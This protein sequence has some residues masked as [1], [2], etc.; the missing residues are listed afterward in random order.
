MQVAPSAASSFQQQL[1]VSLASAEASVASMK[2]RVAE[3]NR[4]LEGLKAAVNAQPQVEAEFVQLTRDYEVTKSNYER[5][6][7]RREQAQ[8]SGEMESNASVMDFRV[9]DPPTVPAAP[10]APNRPALIT[11]IMLM[12]LGAGI[13]VAFVLSQIRPTFSDEK[14]LRELSG[15]PVFGAVVMAWT[16]VQRNKR[17]KGLV[18]FLLSLV[19][20]LSAYG[21][22]LAALSLR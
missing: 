16:D 5:L 19:S 3:Y 6:L 11:A 9:I 22:V 4:R 13:G 20:L 14:R 15:L 7:S 2:A 8:M 17:R 12:A 21:T 18:A 10:N 1:S